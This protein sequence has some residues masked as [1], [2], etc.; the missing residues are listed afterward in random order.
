MSEKQV[1]RY[2]AVEFFGP[3][4]GG[5]IVGNRAFVTPVDHPDTVNVTNGRP[6]YT[7]EVVKYDEVTEQFETRNTL[8]VP[9]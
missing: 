9:A 6:A 5:A 7:T 3:L 4:H 1:V 8:Y 2:T